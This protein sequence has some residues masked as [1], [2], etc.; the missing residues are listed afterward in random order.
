[1]RFEPWGGCRYGQPNRLGLPERLL[2]L[3]ESHYGAEDRATITQEVVVEV[4]AKAEDVPYRYR[5]FTS[6]FKAL[7]GAEQEPTREAL[8]EFCHAIA[9]Y[10]FVQD[11]IREA[12]DRPNEEAWAGGITP[13]FEGLDRLTPSHVVACGFGLW[14]SLPSE[15]F[16][17]LAT[18]TD[19]SILEQLP[20][21]YQGSASHR[22]RGWVGRYDYEGGR[23]V[24]LKIHHP[25]RA[26]SAPEWR[27][28]LQRFLRLEVD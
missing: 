5:F 22:Q 17:D 19:R 2:V 7:C 23:C 12:G 28:V 9:F 13:F 3:G 24:I 4:F 21:R 20:S 11:M 27:P 16:S 6:V 10:N 25:S 15:H 1:M 14:D 26:F 18:E 8:A